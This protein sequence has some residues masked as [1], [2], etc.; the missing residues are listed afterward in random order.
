MPK[1]IRI[2]LRHLKLEDFQN[3]R[4]AM[5]QAY[6]D[7]AGAI[8][9]EDHIR[10]LIARFPDGQFCVTVNGQVVASA[11]SIIVDYDL[12]GDRHTYRQ[13]TGNYTF[14]TH[15]PEGD[16]LYGIDVFV[17]PEYRGM[18]LARRLY[19]ARKELCE[20]LNLKS[21]VA[22]GRIPNYG[23]YADKLKPREYID[24]VKQKE[25]YDPTLSFQLSN[26]F[27]VLKVMQGYLQGDTSSLEYATLL[28]WNNI[29]YDQ[30][31]KIAGRANEVVRLGLV[32]WQMRP[33][34]NL[35][36]LC[37]QVEFFVD[38][39]SSY[40]AD[41]CLFPELFNAPLLAEFNDLDEA[42][43]MRGLAR[44]TEPLRDK[45]IDYA[46]RYNVNII[47][48]SMPWQDGALLKNVGYLCRRDG[49]W[50]K[51]EKVHITPN[52]VQYWGM[53]GGDE[54]R[55]FDTDCGKI[56]ILI[57]YDVEFPE[58]SRLLAMQGM[59]I[60]FVPFLTDTQNGYMRVRRC[61]QARAIEN[62]CYVAI[63]GS[64]GNLPKV[65]NMDIQFAQSA[66]FT[67]SDF[68]FPTKGIKSE[69]TPNTEMTLIVDVD[70]D[71]LKELNAHGSVRIM[72][73][74]R[75]DLYDLKLLKNAPRNGSSTKARNNT[76]SS[77]RA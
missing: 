17:H 18:R 9:R 26:D 7:M 52:E 65:E 35:D 5:V 45:F 33:M 49:T 60:L 25:I 43:A 19:E 73:D 12:Y 14:S 29:Y 48:G 42:S 10:T 62:E 1:D 75:T 2:R 23:K 70:R 54:V 64:V 24:K 74:R 77:D 63:A 28:E 50:E 8:W 46:I 67:P 71:L 4:E 68:A 21:I 61:A 72:R 56:G 30:R 47:T 38:A 53:K 69:A 32:Q 58:L 16:V 76:R 51:F 34:A 57:C 13:I 20:R 59:Q 27:H 6:P 37:D 22:G 41:F 36:A 40:Q 3:L 44:Y 31:P 15:D 11:L 66:V 55:V 39:I